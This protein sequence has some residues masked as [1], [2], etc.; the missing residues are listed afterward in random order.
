MSLPAYCNDL[1][2]EYARALLGREDYPITSVAL[3]AGY[4]DVSYFIQKFKE[5]FGITPL[6]YR[7]RRENYEKK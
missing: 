5:K 6:Q 3:D 7:K 4:N 1:K 2:L